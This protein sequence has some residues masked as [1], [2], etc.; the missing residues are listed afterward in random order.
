MKKYL[1]IVL[2]GLFSF[3]I[4]NTTLLNAQN[5]QYQIEGFIFDQYNKPI[6]NAAIS[7]KNWQVI[8]NT[9]INGKFS[10]TSADSCTIINVAKDNYNSMA[11]IHVCNA[12]T[13]T[14][15]LGIPL[16]DRVAEIEAEEE[17]L[18]MDRRI[19][20]HSARSK[21]SPSSYQPIGNANVQYYATSPM[22]VDNFPIYN[23]EDYGIIKENRF[24]RPTDNPLSTFSIDVDAASYSN[25]R[26]FIQN[27]QQPPKD[28]VRIEEMIN[29]FNYDNPQPTDE[30]PFHA[31][32]EMTECPWSPEHYLLQISLQG[33]VIPTDDLPASNLV[34]LIDVSGSMSAANKLPLLISSFKLLT[35]Q[36][37]PQDKVSI[38][39]YAGAA[40]VVLEPTSGNNKQ[41]IK[42][43][44]NKL[45]AGGS[46]AGGKGIKLAYNLARKNFIEGGNNRVVLATDGDFNVGTS[47][48]AGLVRMIEKERESGVF[49]TVLGFGMGNYKDN[50]MQELADKGNGNHAYIDNINEARKVLISEFG[51]TMFTIAKDV[52]LQLE[53]NPAK[54]GG[55]RLIGYENRMLNKE[56]FND[57][58]KDAGELGSGH[59]VT[60][61]YEI[62]P[63]GKEST[64]LANVDELKYQKT[65][66]VTSTSKDW[67]TLKLRYKQPDGDKSQLLQ[68][69]FDQSPVPFK[70]AS[71]N[72]R[73]AS[74]VTEFGL[75][76]RDSPFKQEAKY[77]QAIEIATA[78]LG[79][80][81]EGYRAE[82]IKLMEA[83]DDLTSPVSAEKE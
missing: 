27:G 19:A 79:E 2:C 43:A 64:F 16:T 59:T 42:D 10:F 54:V 26:R 24:A 38:V 5:K 33:E 66:K 20:M 44:L 36:L 23:T 56:D 65:P 35:N 17:S 30:H 32:M 48:D 31:N 68:L 51:G 58:K 4:F 25:L 83:M 80:D 57:D 45:Q 67:I 52:K 14:V 72:L 39:V 49:L 62:I 41:I 55:Y 13:D 29:Y 70:K 11:F 71:E 50:K 53:F 34:F 40:G 8:T 46:T 73:W 28:A 1:L 82:C 63:A 69:V 47:S 75:L 15:N 6:E 18:L 61:I 7:G 77:S 74:A 78:A 12:L 9:D 37:R 22:V 21:S 76:L 81:K 60:A 3:S